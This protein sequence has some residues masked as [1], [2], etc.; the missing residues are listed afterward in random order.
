MQKINLI[1]TLYSEDPAEPVLNLFRG[2]FPVCPVC[3]EPG[4]QVMQPAPGIVL[5][6][7]GPGAQ[8]PAYIATACQPVLSYRQDDLHRAVALAIANGAVL[9]QQATDERT[10]FTFCYLRYPDAKVIGFF[11]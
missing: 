5:Q 4:L 9:L 1:V 6:V 11:H 10:G 2:I 8:P 3:S 7:F